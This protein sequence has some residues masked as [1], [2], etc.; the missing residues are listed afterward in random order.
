MR[1]SSPGLTGLALSGSTRASPA[2]TRIMRRRPLLRSTI[3]P[4]RG[5]RTG[6]SACTWHGAS[7]PTKHPASPSAAASSTPPTPRRS[8]PSCRLTMTCASF[9]ATHRPQHSYPHRHTG[10]LFSASGMHARQ[11][12]GAW[13]S[14]TINA[15]ALYKC[16]SRHQST[17]SHADALVPCKRGMRFL[18]RAR[19]WSCVLVAC[20]VDPPSLCAVT[21]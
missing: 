18:T 6:I 9:A 13:C 21:G 3:A 7:H 15:F 8:L 16:P 4:L 11:L 19:T 10:P 17:D 5:R 20:R 12:G 1:A 14:T 2:Y